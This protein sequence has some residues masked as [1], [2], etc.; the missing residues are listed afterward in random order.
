MESWASLLADFLGIFILSCRL[1]IRVAIEAEF[2][3]D[4]GIRVA[5]EAEFTFDR[6]SRGDS[7]APAPGRQGLGGSLLGR[8]KPRRLLFAPLMQFC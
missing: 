7:F 5:I 2:T 1:G 6:A 8:T 4:R 3:F